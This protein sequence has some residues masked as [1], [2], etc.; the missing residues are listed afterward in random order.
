MLNFLDVWIWIS[1]EAFF[2]LNLIRKLVLSQHVQSEQVNNSLLPSDR[3]VGIDQADAVFAIVLDLAHGAAVR[4]EALACNIGRRI[5][6]QKYQVTFA[7][8]EDLLKGVIIGKHLM[9]LSLGHTDKL[10]FIRDELLSVVVLFKRVQG[11]GM[12]TLSQSG[13]SLIYKIVLGCDST[14]MIHSSTNQVGIHEIL[15][16]KGVDV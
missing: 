2:V 11:L 10:D 7:L 15:R 14:K 3:P 6:L 13:L 9:V 12:S 8:G 5:D 1:V 4:H 16:L